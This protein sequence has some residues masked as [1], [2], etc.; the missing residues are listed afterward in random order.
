MK[1]SLLSYQKESPNVTIALKHLPDLED[2]TVVGRVHRFPTLHFASNSLRR[3]DSHSS[4]RHVASAYMGR[5]EEKP[6]N[7]CRRGGSFGKIDR[8]LRH[9][10]DF[11]SYDDTTQASLNKIPCMGL[12]SF[13]ISKVAP[14]IRPVYD[15]V[16]EKAQCNN[17][18]GL[19]SL[20]M[21]TADLHSDQTSRAHSKLRSSQNR[22]PDNQ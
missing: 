9:M 8:G 10:F 19:S 11:D 2:P 14:L 22:R 4:H 21:T 1:I 20:R 6:L 13:S 12:H 16:Q 17:P 7:R 3:M 18:L 15:Y 5:V